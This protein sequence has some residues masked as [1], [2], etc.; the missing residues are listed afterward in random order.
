M[1]DTIEQLVRHNRV[2]QLSVPVYKLAA[3][4]NVNIKQFTNILIAVDNYQCRLPSLP[5]KQ[6]KL[7]SSLRPTSEHF[8][9]NDLKS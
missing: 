8:R 7:F 6:A 1:D 3:K 2:R 9:G 4:P 5:E